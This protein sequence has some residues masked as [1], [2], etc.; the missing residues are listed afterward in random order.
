MV[1]SKMFTSLDGVYNPKTQVVLVLGLKSHCSYKNFSH[2]MD[3]NDDKEILTCFAAAAIPA[4][5]LERHKV[6]NW[7]VEDTVLRL[8]TRHDVWP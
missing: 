3:L 8:V 6:R 5:T 2:K 7:V 1:P 4:V